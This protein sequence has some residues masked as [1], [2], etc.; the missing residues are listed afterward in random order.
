MI[1]GLMTYLTTVFLSPEW[2]SGSLF[3]MTGKIK[4]IWILIS[5]VVYLI[6][7]FILIFIA[8]MNIL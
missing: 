5:N 2:T 8:F 6:F 4:E 1:L 3:G 7:A